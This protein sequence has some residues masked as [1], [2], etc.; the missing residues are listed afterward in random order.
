M[1]KHKPRKAAPTEYTTDDEDMLIYDVEEELEPDPTDKF[2]LK[3]CPTNFHKGYLRSL[4]PTRF[5]KR[6]RCTLNLS[7]AQTSSHW[8]GNLKRGCQLRCRPRHLTMLQSYEV[9]RQKPSCS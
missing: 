8:Y 7:R 5:R 1:A 4:T 3:E 6:E 9:R 2:I